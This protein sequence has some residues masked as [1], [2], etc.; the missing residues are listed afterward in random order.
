MIYV[1]KSGDGDSQRECHGE[2]SSQR[3]LCLKRQNI[4]GWLQ[5]LSKGRR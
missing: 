5:F 2:E 3:N 4:T 1:F